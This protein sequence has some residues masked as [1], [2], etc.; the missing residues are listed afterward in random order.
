MLGINLPWLDGVNR[1][2][3]KRCIPSVLPKE[4]VSTLFQFLDGDM[5]MLAQLLYGTGMRLMEGLFGHSDM[6]TTMIYTHVLKVAAG[7]T[8]SPLDSLA[9]GG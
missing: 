5:R 1:P 3:Q 2:P 6:S 4:D 9:F 8:A 7:R